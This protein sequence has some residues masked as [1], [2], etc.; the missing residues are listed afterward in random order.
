MQGEV[1]TMRG[2]LVVT[3]LV[4]APAVCFSQDAT[5]GRYQL[6]EMAGGVI[7]LDTSSGDMW[8][9]RDKNGAADCAPLSGTAQGPALEALQ[10]RV[11]RLEAELDALKAKPPALPSDAEVDRSLSIME[12]F[13]RSFF[14]IAREFGLENNHDGPL[15]QKT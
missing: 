1:F 9:C 2:F 13:M 12:K 5:S 11:S 3:F 10:A 6:K 7:R 15:P 4:L 14:G 8:F